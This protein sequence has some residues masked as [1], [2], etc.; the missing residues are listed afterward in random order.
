MSKAGATR[1][2][3][4]ISRVFPATR[5]R[6]FQAW[7]EPNEIKKWWRVG[8]DFVLTV[9]EVDLRVGGEFRIGVESQSGSLHMVRGRFLEVVAP[10]RLVYTWIAEDPGLKAMETL[11]TVEFR[12]RGDGTEISL[13]HE[14]LRDGRLQESTRSGWSSVIEGLSTL[15]KTSS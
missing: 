1:D 12:E 10:K 11:V 5:Q 13:L 9:A 6:T 14:K 8:R 3:L 4:R 15:L 7:T 2:S